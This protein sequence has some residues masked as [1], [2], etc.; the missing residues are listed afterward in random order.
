MIKYFNKIFRKQII[1]CFHQLYYHESRTWTK[2]TFLGYPIQQCP[3]D[4]Y[5]Y[6]ELI[7]NIRPSYIIQTG[8]FAGGSILY[9]ASLL[10][11]IKTNENAIVIGIDIKISDLARTLNHP[12]IKLFEGDSADM[13]IINKIKDILPEGDGMVVLDSDHSREHVLNELNL[14][15]EFI[16]PDGYIVVEDTNIN[17]HPVKP[18][19]GPGPME[20]VNEFL[21][22]SNDFIQDNSLWAR[23]MFSFHQF[24]WLKRIK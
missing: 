12:R 22:N 20:A 9:F 18:K 5:N 16:K 10:D 7:N 21:N 2:N 14:Y 15:K 4:M 1:N 23:Q 11:L 6:Q 13:T 3:L 19:F 8:I 24:G 17:G